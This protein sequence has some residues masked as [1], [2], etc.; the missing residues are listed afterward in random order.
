MLTA[1]L[2]LQEDVLDEAGATTSLRTEQ[3]DAVFAE[4]EAAGLLSVPI[5]AKKGDVVVFH[6]RLL[7]RVL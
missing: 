7:H 2:W 1:C 3:Q 6:G 5:V 4:N